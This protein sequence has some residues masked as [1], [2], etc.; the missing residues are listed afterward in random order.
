LYLLGAIAETDSNVKIPAGAARAAVIHQ[1]PLLIPLLGHPE[2]QV[3]QLA[4]WAVTQCRTPGLVFDEL[5][6]RW[7][8]EREPAVRADLLFGCVLLDPVRT[9]LLIT[10]AADPQEPDQVRIAALV[11]GI[12]AGLPWTEESA[13]A[14]LSLLPAE[15]RIGQNPWMVAPL[16]ELALRLGQR[17][18][19]DAAGDLLIAAMSMEGPWNATARTE[20]RRAA[21]LLGDEQPESRTRLLPGLLRLLD[22][23]P[24]SR[25]VMRIIRGWQ[26]PAEAIVPT[27]LQL[28]TGEDEQLAEHAQNTL[29]ALFNWPTGNRP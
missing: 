29:T 4:V 17:G 2:A 21:K 18:E 20:A 22:D 15:E 13:A 1:L 24:N 11:A 27:L 8:A 23:P 3:R 9:R 28:A 12:D 25:Y 10:T 6:T 14:T 7:K 26:T 16:I 19:A 5:L